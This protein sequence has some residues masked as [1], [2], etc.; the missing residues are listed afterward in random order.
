MKD[1][2]NAIKTPVSIILAFFIILFLFTKF[3]GPLPFSINSVQT[4]KSTLFQVT[5]TGKVSEAPDS[6]TVSF[7]TTKTAS[8]I[9][10]AQNQTN[11]ATQA[12]L[13]ALRGQG[14]EEKNIKTTNYSV[15][16]NYDFTSGRQSITGYTVT[17]NIDVT[18][19]PIEKVNAVLDILTAN[20]ANIVGQ[21]SF[22]FSDSK[23]QQL[24]NKARELAVKEAKTKAEGLANAAGIR[25]G[26]I[27]DVSEQTNE[28]PRPI[29]PMALAKDEAS[30]GGTP[31]QVTPGENSITLSVTLSYETY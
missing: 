26:K 3:A 21:V 14:I 17:Q 16:P 5:G 30:A 7:G 12:I 9:A 4:T 24:E 6:A 10:D 28:E 22:T 25:L 18:I 31:T 29:M 1:F 11:T 2:L 27:V 20:G 13:S 15:N 8:T 23:K 19:Q